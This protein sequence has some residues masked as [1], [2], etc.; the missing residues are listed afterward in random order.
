MSRGGKK[1]TGPEPERRCIATGERGG[2]AGLIRFVIGPED[3]VVPDLAEKL[4]GR[5]MWVSADAGAIDK[6]A[7]KGL[8]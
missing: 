4:P 2:K 7:R 8:F 1:K 3:Q 6:A 5:G